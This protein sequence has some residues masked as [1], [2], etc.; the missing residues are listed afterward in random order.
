MSKKN[1][2]ANHPSNPAAQPFNIS[3]NRTNKKGWWLRGNNNGRK[4]AEQ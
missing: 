1:Q 3:G 2:Y 4:A